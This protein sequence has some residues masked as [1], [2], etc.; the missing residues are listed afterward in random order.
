MPKIRDRN[1]SKTAR[2]LVRIRIDRPH[3]WKHHFR[4]VFAEVIGYLEFVGQARPAWV[5]VGHN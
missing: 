4:G 3:G 2:P 5:C 1:F